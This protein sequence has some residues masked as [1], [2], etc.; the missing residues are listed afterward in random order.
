MSTYDINIFE[1]Y[2]FMNKSVL[3]FIICILIKINYKIN[4]VGF[5]MIKCVF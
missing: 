3:A 4:K 2:I 5:S 1:F